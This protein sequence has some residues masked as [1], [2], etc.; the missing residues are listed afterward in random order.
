[1]V[2]VTGIV[3]PVDWDEQGNVIAT[4][5]STYDEKLYHINPDKKGRQ[6]ALLIREAVRIR[7]KLAEVKGKEVLTVKAY[8]LVHMP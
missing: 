4:G 6:L 5:V 8:T 7:G 3:I 1:M 2:D